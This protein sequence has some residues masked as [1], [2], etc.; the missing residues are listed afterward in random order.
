MGGTR[1]VLLLV[2]LSGAAIGYIWPN[3]KLAPP[4]GVVQSGLGWTYTI[5][6][7]LSFVPQASSR[8]R[9]LRLVEGACGRRGA[10]A[11]RCAAALSREGGR[12]RT[13]GARDARS[14]GDGPPA[15]DD[16]EM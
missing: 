11:R 15:A 4:W 10:A 16:C 1:K 7:G 5:A 12:K 6:W 13:A 2:L 8:T 14:R 9:T 3:T